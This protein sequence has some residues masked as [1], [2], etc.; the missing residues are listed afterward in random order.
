MAHTGHPRH[1]R[2]RTIVNALLYVLRTGYAWRLLP[3]DWPAWQS[4]YYHVRKWRRDGT[5]ER[6][7]TVLR[8]QLRVALGRDPQPS[9]GSVD[10]QSVKTTSV[11]GARGYDGAKKL[12]G[13]KRDIL[14]D[15]EGLLMAVNVHPA[16]VMGR[17]GIKR[18][19]DEP[20]RARL[21]GTAPSLVGFELQRLGQRQQLGRACRWLDR[22]RA[23]GDPSVQALLGAQGYPTRPDRLVKVSATSRIPCASEKM[24]H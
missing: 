6:I 17:D 5:L 7:H 14:V 2:L 21:P 15:T 20:T 4:V 23:A 18:V 16:N 22:R 13:Q 10:R 3:S 12:V 9:A 19:L 8:E 1:H 11:G 24:G